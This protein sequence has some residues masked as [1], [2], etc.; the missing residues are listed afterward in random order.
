MHALKSIAL[1]GLRG[2]GKTTLGKSLANKLGFSFFDLDIVF[3]EKMEQTI[4][5][6]ILTHTWEDFREQEKQI[7]FS[8]PKDNVVLSCGGGVI[9][10]QE[11][12]EKLF[13]EYFTVFLDVP[14]DELVKRLEKN[15]LK[16]QRPA[17]TKKTL[18]EEMQELYDNRIKFYQETAHLIETNFMQK[19]KQCDNIIYQ[20]M[21][22]LKKKG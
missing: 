17:F 21:Q 16:E 1:I 5:D 8:M 13:S 12:R 2:S 11:N 19:E 6:F 15:A 9:L 7:L 20:F 18:Q 3:Q 22:Q 14:I 4:A 10:K